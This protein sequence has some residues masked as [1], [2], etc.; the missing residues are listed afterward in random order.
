MNLARRLKGSLETGTDGYIQLGSRGL[1]N[2]REKVLQARIHSLAIRRSV[3]SSASATPFFVPSS[4]S[5]LPRS[6]VQNAMLQDGESI[7]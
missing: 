3:V 5:K 2:G 1:R 7:L 4:Q 6:V